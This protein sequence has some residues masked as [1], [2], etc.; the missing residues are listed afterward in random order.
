MVHPKQTSFSQL[1][2]WYDRLLSREV[3]GYL[4]RFDDHFIAHQNYIVQAVFS[5]ASH[6]TYQLS[7]S[8]SDND[9]SEIYTYSPGLC[10]RAKTGQQPQCIFTLFCRQLI[11][12]PLSPSHTTMYTDHSTHTSSHLHYFCITLKSSMVSK[13]SVLDLFI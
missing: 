4:Y 1:S 9:A 12:S 8:C 7:V 6:Y 2:L 5:P 11:Q 10:L 3:S 13:H